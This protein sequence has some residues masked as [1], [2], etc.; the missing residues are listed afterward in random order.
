ML[1]GWIEREGSPVD[2]VLAVAMAG[3]RSYTGEDVAEL[4]CHG[5]PLVLRTVLEMALEAGARLAEPGEFTRRAFLNGRI[6]LTRAEAI[7]DIV[8]AGSALGLRVSAQQLRGRLYEAIAALR[9]EVARVAALVA[10]GID[11]PEEDVVFAHRAELTGRLRGVQ[12]RLAALLAG[13]GRGRIL[14]EGLAV[15]IVGRPNVGKSSLLN[16]LLRENRAI[17][18]E[19]PGT[20]R[21]TVA[22]LAEIGGLALRLVDTAGI[23]ASVDRLEA[24]G[25]TRARAALAQADLALL[26]LDGAEPLTAEDEVLLGEVNPA[27]TLAVV[28]KQD[29]LGGRA[30][31]WMERLAGLPAVILSARS[32]EGVERLEAA[33]RRWA[34]SDERPLLE[35][36]MITNLRQ[37]QA[38]RQ[39]AEA[40]GGAL[41]AL[42]AGLG[43]ELLALDLERVLA[44]L[45]DIVGE[46]TADDL[47]HRIF[48][49]FC[50]GK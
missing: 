21:D 19:L 30:P 20:T 39:A 17:V 13:A 27:A 2:E 50:I 45:G 14:R 26:V 3:P 22:E 40:V 23:R 49:E 34:L 6:D 35:D 24:E 31:D 43:D 33:L 15:A 37:E 18:S 38:A 47:L 5:G 28:N 29:R 48:A 9:E 41:A 36:A 25:V 12:E 11:F 42:E 46:T 32:G 16:A 4:H 1:H 8:R 7:G 10:A 44:A